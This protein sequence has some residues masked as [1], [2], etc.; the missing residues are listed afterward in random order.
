MDYQVSTTRTDLEGMLVDES[1]EPKALPFS[2]LDEITGSFSQYHEIG[3]GGFA[4]VY[5]G[6]LG[7]GTVA[8]KKL[9]NAYIHETEF[10]REVECLMSVRHKNIV[11]FLGY[12]ADTQGSMQRYK[13]KYVM[14]DVQQR[15]LCFEYVPKGSLHDYITDASCGL[16]W[17]KRYPIIKG[18]CEGLNYLHMNRVI[19]LDLKPANI[20]MDDSMEPKIA[21]FGLSRC[22]D[23]GQSL[24]MVTKVAGTLGYLPPEFNSR[25]VTRHYDIYSLGVI[26]MEIM[27]GGK[28][29]H[30]IEDVLDSWRNRLEETLEDTELEQIRVCANIGKE[31]T[32]NNPE[33]RPRS[34]QHIIDRLNETERADESSLE[35]I[36]CTIDRKSFLVSM[37]VHPTEPWYKNTI[38]FELGSP[39]N[40]VFVKGI[41]SR[42]KSR[43]LH[44]QKETW[45]CLIEEAWLCREAIAQLVAAQQRVSELTPLIEE[46][47]S[48]RSR[49]AE[50]RCHVD[51]AEMAF[52]ALSARSRRD[53][54][55]AAKV[56]KEQDE[57][58]QKD[59][60]TH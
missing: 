6:I 59:I 24:V 45:D 35:M 43:F 44:E 5:R 38:G 16:P 37:D 49:V 8:V 48:L 55:E 41:R 12:C 15:L 25:A 42:G 27:T 53:N 10:Q 60:E 3:R 2:L 13:N 20:L 26:I 56:R 52:E 36:I 47:D 4:V 7:T 32:K 19:H 14:A 39:R 57:L 58:L 51:E 40:S 46:A 21:D 22:F 29:Y 9:S 28:G 31:C 17:R 18:V 34:V 54:E 1:M 11:R 23:E 50:A 30:A 33:K